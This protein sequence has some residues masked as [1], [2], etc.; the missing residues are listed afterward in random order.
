MIKKIVSKDTPL[1]EITLRKYEKP[2]EEISQRDAIKKLCL[3]IGLLQPGDSR[4]I[5]VDIFHVLIDSKQTLDSNEIQRK[6]I[7]FR[8]NKNLTLQGVAQSNIRRQLRRLRELF[9]VEKVKNTYRIAENESLHN[10]FE[11]KIK[12]FIIPTIMARVEEYFK[13][14]K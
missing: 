8:K 9:L 2:G 7:E 6:V 11:E 12:K 10:I 1:A 4:D 3:S 13:I 14:I 5:I